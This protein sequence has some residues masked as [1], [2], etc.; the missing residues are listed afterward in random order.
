[1]FATIVTASVL[2][3]NLQVA[4][5]QLPPSPVLR[6]ADSAMTVRTARTVA[7]EEHLQVARRA[8]RDGNFDVARREFTAAATSD[9]DAG[10]LPVE[11]TFGLASALYAQAYNREAAITMERLANE[12]NLRGDT[13]TEA[14]ALADA[15][16]LN[17]DAGQR[18]TARK[19]ADR[20]RL[21]VKDTPLSME[22]RA[23]VKAR[24][25]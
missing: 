12:A 23:A 2:A 7:S 9:R 17:A 6:L 14:I 10:R 8:M 18:I 20:L 22:A 4:T 16:W 5:L 1:M 21:L 19:L 25:G 15:I 13:D 24:L 11:A 3:M